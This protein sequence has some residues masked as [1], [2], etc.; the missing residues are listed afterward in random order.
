M[1]KKKKEEVKEDKMKQVKCKTCKHYIDKEDAQEVVSESGWGS[2][3]EYFCI[4]CPN[5]YDEIRFYSQP[6][7]YWKNVPAKQIQVTKEGKPLKTKTPNK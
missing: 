7:T 2:S 6:I 5:P 3:Y 4:L 1:F